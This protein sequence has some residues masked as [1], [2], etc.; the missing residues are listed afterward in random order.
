M[1]KHYCD[2]LVN[3]KVNRNYW[4]TLL[5]STQKLEIGINVDGALIILK[6]S[7]I[8]DDQFT[9]SVL[10]CGKNII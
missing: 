8:K 5:N 4:F 10:Q 7:I 1:A 6:I 9:S 3:R 2:H